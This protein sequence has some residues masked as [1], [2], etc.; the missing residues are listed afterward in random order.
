M[1]FEALLVERAAVSES[2]GGGE[3]ERE[4][5]RAQVG[6]VEECRTKVNRALCNLFFSKFAN[7]LK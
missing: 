6:R 1:R 2:E 5:E 7:K 3:R 4:R